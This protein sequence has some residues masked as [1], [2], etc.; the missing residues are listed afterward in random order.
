MGKV[1]RSEPVDDDPLNAKRVNAATSSSSSS[2]TPAT[3]ASAATPAAPSGGGSSATSGS[4]STTTTTTA[5]TTSVPASPFASVKEGDFRGLVKC[6]ENRVEFE[7]DTV[8]CVERMTGL[9]TK[10]AEAQ[11]PTDQQTFFTAT[12]LL[13]FVKKI[14]NHK[15]TEDRVIEKLLVFLKSVIESSISFLERGASDIFEV[16]T[17][18]FNTDLVFYLAKTAT[19]LTEPSLPPELCFAVV[20]TVTTNVNNTM[21][22]ELLNFFGAKK[23]FPIFLAHIAKGPTKCTI[24]DIRIIVE[25]FFLMKNSKCLLPTLQPTLISD[26]QTLVNNR[27]QNI[28]NEEIKL[29][30]KDDVDKI[31][32][33]LTHLLESVIPAAECGEIMETMS[34]SVALKCFTSG[35]LEKRVYGLQSISNMSLY[36]RNSEQSAP[37]STASKST[38]WMTSKYFIKWLEDNGVIDALYGP[39]AHQQL[40]SRMSDLLRFLATAN[41]LTE[42]HLTIMWNTIMNSHETVATT[43]ARSI[44]ADCSSFHPDKIELL[45]S[46]IKALPFPS[47]PMNVLYLINDLSRKCKET[48][49]RCEMIEL[50]WQIASCSQP[51]NCSSLDVRTQALSYLQEISKTPQF[52]SFR[53]EWIKKLITNIKEGT[54][55]GCNYE[56]LCAIL[57]T[58]PQK[59]EAD[60]KDSASLI[61][62]MEGEYSLLEIFL[63]DF[64]H[65]IKS[66]TFPVDKNGNDANKEIDSRLS[67]LRLI[68]SSSLDLK[69]EQLFGLWDLMVGSN[70]AVMSEIFYNW[71]LMIRVPLV[72]GG[73]A[74]I[75]MLAMIALFNDKMCSGHTPLSPCSEAEFRCF[76]AWFGEINSHLKLVGWSP[77][78]PDDFEV[79]SKPKKLSGYT[80]LWEIAFSTTESVS[81]S[82]IQ[83]LQRIHSSFSPGLKKSVS[84][85]ELHEEFLT[86]CLAFLS[87]LS[88]QSEPGILRCLLIL[89]QYISQYDT[90][91]SKS[92]SHGS[93]TRGKPVTL[94]VCLSSAMPTASPSTTQPDSTAQ[95]KTDFT[96]D[97]H[98][99]VTVGDL[100]QHIKVSLGPNFSGQTSD[101]II[102]MN[103]D[104]LLDDTVT[105]QQLN[106]TD[107]QLVSVSFPEKLTSEQQTYN[108][109][110][111]TSTNSYPPP[112]PPPPAVAPP[113]DADAKIAQL[114]DFCAISR[115]LAVVVLTKT[116]WVIDTAA[117]YMFDET[118]R[119]ELTAEAER[120]E[121][122]AP[123]QSSSQSS[124][125]AV[126]LVFE[127]HPGY[128]IASNSS[129][130]DQIF[131]LLN[132]KNS[133]I[134]M[135]TWELLMDIPTAKMMQQDM[136]F[137]KF[138]RSGESG[139]TPDWSELFDTHSHF[140]MLYSLQ[141]VDSIVFPLDMKSVEDPTRINWCS[142]FLT[143]G[144]L[145]H[146]YNMLCTSISNTALFSDA[147]QAVYKSC[148]ALILKIVEFFLRVLSKNVES[149][150]L[151]SLILAQIPPAA[152][153][154][155]LKIFD[156]KQLQQLLLSMIWQTAAQ[157][158]PDRSDGLLVM[159]AMTLVVE[160][161][162]HLKAALLLCPE[163][164]IRQ[165]CAEGLFELV[166]RTNHLG[167]LTFFCTQ[168]LQFLPETSDKFDKAQTKYCKQ[169]FNLMCRLFELCYI[170]GWPNSL[171]PSTLSTHIGSLIRSRPIVELRTS[172]VDDFLVG[173][174]TLLNSLLSKSDDLKRS[175]TLAWKETG[176][177]IIGDLYLDL[178]AMRAGVDS[179]P[180]PKC[181]SS[182]AR[183][184]ILSL[185]VELCKNHQENLIE[186]IQL[187]MPHHSGGLKVTSW[188]Y[189][190]GEQDKTDSGFV[191][192]TNLGNTCYMNSFLQQLFMI[193]GLVKTLLSVE[194]QEPVE[195]A[196]PNAQP[197]STAANPPS[198]LTKKS[199]V[200]Q[201]Q[202]MFANLQE[203]A[204]GVY[205]TEG[206]CSAYQEATG[207]TMV[208]HHQQDVDEFFNFLWQRLEQQL[209]GTPQEKQL[210]TFFV[211]KLA[212]QIK[213]VEKDMPYSS[214][215]LEDFHVLSIDIKNKKTLEEAFDLYV[216]PDK[217][218]GDNAFYCDQYS[219]KVNA[220]KRVCVKEL[221]PT[222]IVHLKRFEY[223]FNANHKKLHDFL[224][225]PM[226]L[227]MKPWTIEGLSERDGLAVSEREREQ[228]SALPQSYY[229]YQL[230]GVLVH[231]GEA[232]S[233]HY[234][235]I[236]KDRTIGKWYEFNDRSVSR[237][238]V[239]NLAS[240]CYGGKH[241]ISHWDVSTKQQ[242]KSESTR[243]CSAYMLFYEKNEP[244][245]NPADGI[246]TTGLL[247][248]VHE[249]N[250]KFIR[251]CQLFDP[252]YFD[253]LLE[254][255]KL[256]S[257]K[258]KLDLECDANDVAFKTLQLATYF[259]FETLAHA[260]HS[261]SFGDWINQL[262]SHLS[263]H[264][265][266]CRWLLE[267]IRTSGK[268]KEMLLE[269]TVERIRIYVS[270]LIIHALKCLSPLEYEIWEQYAIEPSTKENEPAISLPQAISV[271]FMEAVFDLLEPCRGYWKRFKQYFK[272]YQGFAAMGHKQ[273]NYLIS[274]DIFGLYND[275]FMGYPKNGTR[276]L[277]MDNQTL[278]DLVEFI[279]A[280]GF[281]VR[282]CFQGPFEDG[283]TPL[284]LPNT[285]ILPTPPGIKKHLI[286]PVF[287]KAMLE[288]NYNNPA[289]CEMLQHLSWEDSC[290]SKYLITRALWILNY[291]LPSIEAPEK[292]PIMLGHLESMLKVNDSLQDMRA[293]IILANYPIPNSE[294]GVLLLIHEHHMRYVPQTYNMVKFIVR[295]Y[296]TVP[297]ATRYLNAHQNELMWISSY[298]DHK[299]RTLFGPECLTDIEALTSKL[300]PPPASPVESAPPPTSTTTN[301][302]STQT[303]S[304]DKSWRRNSTYMSLTSLRNA[305][306]EI[307]LPAVESDVA[308]QQKEEA[309]LI[310]TSIRE[311]K[312]ALT[313]YKKANPDVE[314]QEKERIQ[315]EMQQKQQA[316]QQEPG[317]AT[318]AS[319]TNQQQTPAT[320]QA[321]ASTTKN[322]QPSSTSTTLPA[323]A[324]VISGTIPAEVP[325]RPPS[326]PPGSLSS[327]TT[328]TTDGGGNSI[329]STT[330]NKPSTGQQQTPPKECHN[331][332]CA[333]HH[334]TTWLPKDIEKLVSSVLEVHPEMSRKVVQ[335]A[336]RRYEWNVDAACSE[337]FEPEALVK[338]I[339]LSE[340]EDHFVHKGG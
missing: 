186:L 207:Q 43:A 97:L 192:L 161:T 144:G 181:K 247:K 208:I 168:L 332:D 15:F 225:F 226:N 338:I 29:M 118:K 112:A 294:K 104:V 246:L 216:A 130:F 255:V 88:T 135:R 77:K 23:G 274:K 270:D 165:A 92:K 214:E 98:S 114:M 339:E 9:L 140:K 110:R 184:A 276:V 80:R 293:I 100:R 153:D 257:F 198:H 201:L 287:L 136:H 305:M 271:R 46:L 152:V 302:S 323:E 251:D 169:Y 147:T 113:A 245:E 159:Y 103:R 27:L 211:G 41:A 254:I 158:S 269:C 48:Q 231:S 157:P 69:L 143:Q 262:K 108:R 253:F 124:S 329:S 334:P 313:M 67:F 321:T 248:Q 315:K 170:L 325:S 33:Q 32:L 35:F 13:G 42:A 278:P 166:R 300:P 194:L 14:M 117:A 244:K 229:E 52:K 171:S 307:E 322:Q 66:A 206:F 266:A 326:A 54:A 134:C 193:K 99:N 331:P 31:I 122:L 196:Q 16:L 240:E 239:K 20:P 79:L 25:I 71:L 304:E 228:A 155:Q 235:S 102:T 330:T 125:Q 327:N 18:I 131:Q 34:L 291:Y 227:N 288:M 28:T 49:H 324:P 241:T 2:T 317:G 151:E 177:S 37:Q 50:L 58:F 53:M 78:K 56:L 138:R 316:Q 221:P 249:E 5:T 303:P 243:T 72:E 127:E 84:V 150:S 70:S 280:L 176:T 83:L 120:A 265:P 277:V 162:Q 281:I 217:L 283:V 24:S 273:R 81:R 94:R 133:S 51:S 30:K 129:L 101:I 175:I 17:Y 179:P 189:H 105:L 290:R 87:Q 272:L 252:A 3:A 308:L 57:S 149:A 191:G 215:R 62:D 172:D 185:L 19:P 107:K 109:S 259:V 236:I 210:P 297:S 139:E 314:A 182:A 160:G 8:E 188:D 205:N 126:S 296:A 301:P 202:A 219:S 116:G 141:M 26:L 268:L 213:S 132:S 11:L 96:L 319:S 318:P 256:L 45:L 55:V 190:P 183:I 128:L 146:L 115:S 306:K 142:S 340:K 230:V 336:L 220:I 311:A 284:T 44:G 111:I 292:I 21:V 178:F 4:A 73:N 74:A 328:I 145:R 154:L 137:L 106:V 320:T 333:T 156:F 85:V 212:N 279:G 224:E 91:Q 197:T 298:L 68:L 86:T 232:E 335:A 222:L 36:I 187:I 310:T 75:G 242:V 10:L 299:L 237:F 260:R 233:G 286:E 22:V 61:K 275:W 264:I 174:V 309:V 200:G 295:M 250:A 195:Q 167:A 63:V 261:K 312:E 82:A 93:T 234:Y 282:G 64:T 90:A 65:Y 123:S 180:F 47:M 1:A 76:K 209:K 95:T 59:Q 119:R 203:S 148:L 289:E 163:Q 173:L 89:K 263:N 238:D 204:K 39:S 223:D 38:K 285:T 12:G 267:Y 40:L 199:L 258:P 218:E 60:Q 121:L 164:S 337:L 6:C 7:R